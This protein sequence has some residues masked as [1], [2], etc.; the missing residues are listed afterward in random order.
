LS[1]NLY[2]LFGDQLERARAVLAGRSTEEITYAIESL[3]YLLREGSQHLFAESVE[4][5]KTKDHHFINRVKALRA[6]RTQMDI[7]D[8]SHLPNATWADYFAAMALACV[9]ESLYNVKHAGPAFVH[10]KLPK[11]PA[12]APDHVGYADVE[13]ALEA[14]DAVC[15]A[16]QLFAEA[17]AQPAT[18][19]E[20]LTGAPAR[21]HAPPISDAAERGSKGGKVRAAKYGTLKDKVVSLYETKYQESRSNREAARRIFDEL[22]AEDLSVLSDN[23]GDQ[24]AV[25]RFAKWIGE[26]KKK[27]SEKIAQKF[28]S[29]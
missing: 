23:L 13:L 2:F 3:D 22:S 15:F 27:Q 29:S 1:D 4:V 16:E 26:H 18:D 9:T 28:F 17:L 25:E 21:A 11:I 20:Q 10:P 14:M 6:Y 24:N 5:L 12:P 19:A 7:T 8:Q